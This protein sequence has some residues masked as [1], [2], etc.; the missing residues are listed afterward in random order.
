MMGSRDARVFDII[1]LHE[2]ERGRENTGE[3]AEET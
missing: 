1:L 3:E 2:E